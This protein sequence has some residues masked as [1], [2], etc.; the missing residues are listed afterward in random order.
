MFLTDIAFRQT[1]ADVLKTDV[2]KMAPGWDRVCQDA[3]ETAYKDIRRALLA[4]GFSA[5]AID[6][7]DSGEEFER[8]IGVWWAM[9]KARAAGLC[10]IT[11]EDIQPF[12]RREELKTVFVETSAGVPQLPSGTPPAIA[13]GRFDT[14]NDTWTRET[15]V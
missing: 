12:D 1:I 15:R 7:W 11:T 4:R 9:N 13:A 10:K 2:S 5:A 3:H 14:T 8:D 6:A